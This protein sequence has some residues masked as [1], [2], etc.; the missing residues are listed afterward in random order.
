M[1]YTT[2]NS[3]QNPSFCGRTERQEQK[4]QNPE[5]KFDRDRIL[6]PNTHLQ[7]DSPVAIHEE[8]SPKIRSF[9][10]GI[11]EPRQS[12]KTRKSISRIEAQNRENQSQGSF[13]N[14]ERAGKNW[15]FEGGIERAQRE[16][17]EGMKKGEKREISWEF[18]E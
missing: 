5:R 3:N 9:S 14:G 16:F 17:S 7:S 15:S 10:S 11:A 4:Q 2:Q 13:L 6:T 12:R 8:S 18:G 1:S